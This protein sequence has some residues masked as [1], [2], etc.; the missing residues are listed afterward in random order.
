MV[1]RLHNFVAGALGKA[2]YSPVTMKSD[3]GQN[4]SIFVELALLNVL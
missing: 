1:I 3:G 2:F 4:S